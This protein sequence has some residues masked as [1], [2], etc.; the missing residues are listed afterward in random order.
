MEPSRLRVLTSLRFVAALLILHYHTRERLAVGT[1]WSLRLPLDNG[2]SFFFVLSGFI[3][4]YAYPSLPDRAAVRRFLF[5]RLARLWPLHAFAIAVLFAT[6]SGPYVDPHPDDLPWL[7]PLNLALVHAWLPWGKIFFSLNVVSWS[8]STELFFYLCFPFLIRDFE[9]TWRVKLA[10]SFLLVV[11]L[12]LIGNALGLPR[13]D[14]ATPGITSS[15]L[16]YVNPLGRLFEFVLGMSGTVLWR[17]LRAMPAGSPGRA[18]A[19]EL[20]VLAVTVV[21]FVLRPTQYVHI[22]STGREWLLHAGSC[23]A[24]ALLIPVMALERG[25]AS[26]VLSARGLVILGEVSFSLYMFHTIVL[27]EADVHAPGLLRS[28]GVPAMALLWATCIAVSYVTWRFVELPSR[29]IL[30]GWW[31]SRSVVVGEAPAARA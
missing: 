22:G 19:I 16:V 10:G 27:R 4:A 26:R 5:A 6:F 12:I 11:L 15:G 18:T 23:F 24:F 21:W 29:R 31:D 28:L 25:R 1:G 7:L 30:L 17:R 3:L 9:N 14:P 20:V 8:I 13:Y 2:V